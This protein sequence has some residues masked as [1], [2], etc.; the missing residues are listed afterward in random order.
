MQ[1]I[2]V[3]WDVLLCDWSITHPVVGLI[4]LQ[5]ITASFP[6]LSLSSI[7]DSSGV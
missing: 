2:K 5:N 3:V 7:S 6:D 4:S 1:K